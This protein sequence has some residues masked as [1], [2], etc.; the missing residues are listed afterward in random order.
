MSPSLHRFGS[1]CAA[2]PLRILAGW[3]GLI[4][5]LIS[6]ATAIGVGLDSSIR[7]HGSESDEGMH[8]LA[9][10]LPEAAGTIEPILLSAADGNIQG[11]VHVVREFI[12]TLRRIDGVVN[13]IDPFAVDGLAV[14]EDH[15]HAL[16]R[17]IAHDADYSGAF[18]SGNEAGR[19]GEA[20][21]L[22]IAE[23]EA[24]HPQIDI[25]RG[26]VLAPSIPLVPSVSIL[27]GVALAFCVLTLSFG[28][29]QGAAIPLLSA[30]A[31]VAAGV[32]A[33]LLI[34]SSSPVHPMAPMLIA[35]IALAV[36]TAQALSV[37]SCARDH[38]ARAV[39]PVE[40]AGRAVATAGSSVLFTGGAI[41]LSFTALTF[42][43]INLLSAVGL[44]VAGVVVLTVA[45]TVSLTP[46]LVG[47]VGVGVL[48]PRVRRDLRACRARDAATAAGVPL[49]PVSGDELP[50]SRIARR[51]VH[52]F[53]HSPLPVASVTLLVL[54]AS[55]LPLSGLTTGLGDFTRDFTDSV[56]AIEGRQTHDRIARA[57]GP[58][59]NSAL[60]VIADVTRSE[61]PLSLIDTFHGRLQ[62]LEG[63]SRVSRGP[64][65]ADATVALFYVVPTD[66]QEAASTVSLL[67]AIRSHGDVWEKELGIRRV[68]VTGESA[69]SID[70]TDRTHEIVLPF[71]LVLSVLSLV[72]LIVLS[73]SVF[74]SATALL[75]HL[76]SSAAAVSLSALL[77]GSHWFT[78]LVGVA[79]H[80]V[81]SPFHAPLALAVTCAVALGHDITLLARAQEER[82]HTG[83]SRAAFTR[84]YVSSAPQISVS[85]LALSGILSIFLFGGSLHVAMISVTLILGILIDT[86]LVRMSL[87]P[88]LAC[89]LGDTLWRSVLGL[90]RFLP[91]VDIHG[92]GIEH[93]LEHAD[94]VARNG[95]SLVR[96]EHVSVGDKEGKVLN[97]VSFVLRP[98]ELGV[99]SSDSLLQRRVL[100]ALIQG[101][102]T[103][104]SG[105]AVIGSH[106]LPDGLHAV[107]GLSVFLGPE[108]ADVLESTVLVLVD[109]PDS[110]AWEHVSEL[111]AYGI[112]VLVTG[113]E[114]MSVPTRIYPDARLVL[115]PCEC[116]PSH[117]SL[118]SNGECSSDEGSA[119]FLPDPYTEVA[120]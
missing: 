104:T 82:L 46:A 41:A 53:T 37:V 42:S 8:I 81:L 118:L 89:L 62:S 107:Q 93:S 15:A 106:V 100:A 92:R 65:D 18:T 105:R 61:H 31:A 9:E 95:E 112:A 102:L 30:F 39:N 73:R 24:D 103:P 20:L 43:R 50:E 56:S 54:L 101:R 19:L 79:P 120:K 57:F 52:L 67:R 27:L 117:S 7:V 28:S 72:L 21:D 23:T 119:R 12:E 51:W 70:V 35:L 32:P 113:P 109:N 16:V 96:L 76:V 99:V 3:V 85:A 115:S 55:L 34:S 66:R 91:S 5:L 97:G 2:R 49:P 45:A 114:D 90:S 116:P 63:V 111:L 75:G 22:A 98:G 80:T 84:G 69:L 83:E 10:R 108:P 59:E 64:H 77:C 48:R 6:L 88:S 94:W 4:A 68:V 11:H 38:L 58:G 17:V 44:G 36:G 60:L 13:V 25:S 87:L 71:A 110:K 29:L 14:S 78:G 47:L 74:L 86:F 1:W 26:G 33:F 40:A